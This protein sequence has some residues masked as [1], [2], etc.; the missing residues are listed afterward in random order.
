MHSLQRNQT[1]DFDFLRDKYTRRAAEHC[2][3]S[4]P[5]DT[6]AVVPTPGRDCG[7]F[8][9]LMRCGANRAHAQ[10]DEA[11]EN[12]RKARAIP[13]IKQTN[14][15]TRRQ[16]DRGVTFLSRIGLQHGTNGDPYALG[17]IR[18]AYQTQRSAY[19]ALQ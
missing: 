18:N 14:L 15:S 4:A 7:R 1:E 8:M 10:H 6:L 11:H 16:I 12:Q 13:A 2:T 5:R 3:V 19:V 17:Q 9:R